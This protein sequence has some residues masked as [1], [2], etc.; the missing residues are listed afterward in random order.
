MSDEIKTS[1]HPAAA[2]DIIKNID[3][4]FFE[5]NTIYEIYPPIPKDEYERLRKSGKDN[6]CTN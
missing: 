6:Q 4:N 1:I 5:G 3:R 2:K